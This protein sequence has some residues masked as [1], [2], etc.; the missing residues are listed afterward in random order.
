MLVFVAAGVACIRFDWPRVPMLLGFVLGSILERYI[1]LSDS[2]F[3]KGWV[4]RPTVLAI[5][6]L[7]VA[8]L[9]GHLYREGRRARRARVAVAAPTG[10]AGETEG[11][12]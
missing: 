2:L 11:A 8:V 3:G 12:R 5:G 1:F 4:V 9:A 10:A 7:I 6:V